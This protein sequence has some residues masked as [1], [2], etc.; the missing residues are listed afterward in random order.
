ML[1]GSTSEPPRSGPRRDRSG[2]VSGET[3]LRYLQAAADLAGRLNPG[4]D[5]FPYAVSRV[6]MADVAADLGIARTTLYKLWPSKLDFWADLTRFIATAA[7][8]PSADEVATSILQPATEAP[9]VTM[10]RARLELNALQARQLVNPWVVLRTNLL[11][12]AADERVDTLVAAANAREIDEITVQVDRTLT[13]LGVAP[14]EPLTARDIAVVGFCVADGLA[15]AGRLSPRVNAHDI[16]LDGEPPQW[17]MLAFAMRAVMRR[18][19]RPRTDADATTAAA[20]GP[21]RP[22]LL[23]NAAERWSPAQLA[24]LTAGARRFA[25]GA[26]PSAAVRTP[27]PLGHVTIARLARHAGVSRQSLHRIWPSQQAFVADLIPYMFE[28]RCEQVLVTMRDAAR[29]ALEVP[30]AHALAATEQAVATLIR[31]ASRGPLAHLTS[32][33]AEGDSVI[34][35]RCRV[36]LESLLDR[37]TDELSTL[38]RSRGASTRDGVEFLHLATIIVLTELAAARLERTNP[39]SV[40]T[41]LPYRGGHWSTL[42]IAMEGIVGYA[43]DEPTR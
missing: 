28:A 5:T 17:G 32:A 36:V 34:R 18:C 39:G 3:K 22:S 31:D 29:R 35:E 14:R 24:A 12:Y 8:D 37:F 23:L 41:L 40:R 6:T 7:I 43:L 15:T 4:H 42:A 38:T 20:A 11:G 25:T 21:S 13:S 33:S 19:T 2:R 1:D 30:A 26:P 9:R 27:G 10:D 16:A